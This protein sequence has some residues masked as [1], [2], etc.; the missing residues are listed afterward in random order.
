MLV[1]GNK[2][3][4]NVRSELVMIMMA[5]RPLV[6]TS[7]RLIGGFYSVFDGGN[8]ERTREVSA[9]LVAFSFF[10]FVMPEHSFSEVPIQ[11]QNTGFVLLLS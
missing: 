6:R 3:L 5:Y 11:R 9:E 8:D 7:G 4:H 10:F 1:D 2:P